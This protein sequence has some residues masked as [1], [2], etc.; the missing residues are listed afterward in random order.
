MLFA[1]RGVSCRLQASEIG[2][3]RLGS[4]DRYFTSYG[5]APGRRS[6]EETDWERVT[7][8]SEGVA[9]TATGR[10]VRLALYGWPTNSTES[11]LSR[12]VGVRH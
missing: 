8:Y 1:K 6:S 7:C 9:P 3:E 10:T 11:R 2:Y 12:A 4:E 5:C